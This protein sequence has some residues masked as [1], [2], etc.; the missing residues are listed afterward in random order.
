MAVVLQL[1]VHLVKGMMKVV[2][3]GFL[4]LGRQPIPEYCAKELL[5]KFINTLYSQRT[6]ISVT[7]CMSVLLIPRLSPLSTKP[8]VNISDMPTGGADA[9]R[10]WFRPPMLPS[11]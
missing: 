4:H 8:R 2:D 7:A 10:E 6:R 5:S 3:W 1:A 9:C 11:P